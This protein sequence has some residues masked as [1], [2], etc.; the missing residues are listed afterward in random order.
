MGEV[1]VR[2]LLKMGD[3]LA[4]AGEIPGAIDCYVRAAEEFDMRRIPLKAAA[5]YKQILKL[6]PSRRRRKG[7]SD[8]E[9][10]T[11]GR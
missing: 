1:D 6:D 7:A 8:G 2:A 5:I 9:D 4:K 10:V 11:S 3:A